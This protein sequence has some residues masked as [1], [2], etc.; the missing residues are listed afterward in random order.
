MRGTATLGVS[1]AAAFVVLSGGSASAQTWNGTTSNDWT[2]GTNW[3]PNTVPVAGVAVVI[4]TVSPNPTVLGVSAGASGATGNIT[5]GQSG[6]G[7]LTIRTAV[8]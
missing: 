7:N 3:T 6:T 2:V 1:A 8:R 4:D 5:V